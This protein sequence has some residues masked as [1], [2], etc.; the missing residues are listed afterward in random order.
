[1]AQMYHM[2]LVQHT[3]APGTIPDAVLDAPHIAGVLWIPR[4]SHQ[5]VP[6]VLSVCTTHR[7]APQISVVIIH[8]IPGVPRTPVVL[9]DLLVPSVPLASRIQKLHIA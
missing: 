5:P 3:L 6:R 1:M 9:S 8:R 4:V 2:Y 7:D